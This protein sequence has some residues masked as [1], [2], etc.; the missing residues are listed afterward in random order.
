MSAADL[1]SGRRLT[2]RITPGDWRITAVQE[3]EHCAETYREAHSA[4]LEA[5]EL[6]PCYWQAYLAAE[7]ALGAMVESELAGGLTLAEVATACDVADATSSAPRLSQA[8]EAA[9]ERLRER[10]HL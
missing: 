5:T 9:A 4:Q 2:V 6:L 7:A 1:T 3:A 8:R 10:L